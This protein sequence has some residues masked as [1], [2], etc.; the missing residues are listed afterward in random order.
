[1]FEINEAQDEVIKV[2]TLS[3][4]TG[5]ILLAGKPINEPIAT[6]GPFVLNTQEELEQ[7]FRDYS[8][9]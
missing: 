5:F 4:E 7:A 1:M 8:E 9:G 2:K 6:R 3:D